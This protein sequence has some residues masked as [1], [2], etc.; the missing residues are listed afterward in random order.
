MDRSAEYLFYLVGSLETEDLWVVRFL[1][2]SVGFFDWRMADLARQIAGDPEAMAHPCPAVE[3]PEGTAKC[4]LGE[5]P[6]KEFLKVWAMDIYPVWKKEIVKIGINRRY[7]RRKKGNPLPMKEQTPSKPMDLKPV[8]AQPRVK[9]TN[10]VIERHIKAAV[11]AS[12]KGLAAS[13][14]RSV[15]I[16][17][18]KKVEEMKEKLITTIPVNPNPEAKKPEVKPV[19]TETKSE[20]KPVKTE[21][22]SEVKPIKT[23]A[24]SEVKPIKTDAKFEVKP[25]KSATK[26][27]GV[28]P[29]KSATKKPGVKPVKTE[30]KKPAVKP[31]KTETS[32]KQD[33]TVSSR[34]P[35]L[36]A[37]FAVVV[38][39]FVKTMTERCVIVRLDVTQDVKVRAVEAALK[40]VRINLYK[41][42]Q[43]D[44][45]PSEVTEVF[46]L[47]DLPLPKEVTDF[48]SLPNQELNLVL[49]QNPHFP[50]KGSKV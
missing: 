24:K 28:K 39:R 11:A 41:L 47:V 36:F 27:P 12:T 31:V 29:V 2:P 22:K 23:D 20:A 48:K 37:T 42:V 5:L 34:K 25:V 44:V 8:K 26:K 6:K 9:Q 50:L 30:T 7:L 13:N 46:E 3:L 10:N 19:K 14:Q 16:T 21:T 18:Q 38:K 15:E 17:N 49:K 45:K 35:R 1:K 4:L 33:P 32:A 40:F 43:F